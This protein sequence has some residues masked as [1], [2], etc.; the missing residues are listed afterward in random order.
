MHCT[1]H[2]G[3][4]L[5]E[6]L[7]GWQGPDLLLKGSGAVVLPSPR[8]MGAV[9]W[10]YVQQQLHRKHLTSHYHSP[11][12][13]LL[14]LLFFILYGIVLFLGGQAGRKNGLQGGLNAV[15]WRTKLKI[16]IIRSKSPRSAHLWKQGENDP[17]NI[18]LPPLS[19]PP[20]REERLSMTWEL[21][22]VQKTNYM[23]NYMMY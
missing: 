23:Q 8:H 21:W 17:A 18:L 1:T 3:F 5:L 10:E 6:V 19:P 20:K 12:L 16:K 9:S 22:Q 15:W 13:L 2:S 14:L 4:H 11:L 7:R